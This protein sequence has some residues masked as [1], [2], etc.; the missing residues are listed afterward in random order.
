MAM[1]TIC[2][3]TVPVEVGPGDGVPHELIG[4]FKLPVMAYPA[5]DHCRVGWEAFTGE[6]QKRTYDVL[7]PDGEVVRWCWPNAGYMNEA[8]P[9]NHKGRRWG[10]E[11]G[12]K[13]RYSDPKYP[14]T[15]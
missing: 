4:H 1:C 5:P 11:D 8:Y 9:S 15:A 3:N 6:Y 13:V 7:L 2:G 10:I 12:I 14:P